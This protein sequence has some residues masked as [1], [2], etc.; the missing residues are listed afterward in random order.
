M[1]VTTSIRCF[2]AVS[3]N[4][5]SAEYFDPKYVF[6]PNNTVKWKKIGHIL[7]KCQYGIS[8]SMNE[9]ENGFPIFRMNEIDS[10]FATK[11]EKYANITLKKFEEFQL[12]ENDVLFN[13]TNSFE[14]VGRTGLVKNQTDSVFASYLVRVVPD[15]SEVLPEFL[16]VYLNTKFGIGQVKRR[17]MPSINQANVSAAELKRVLVPLFSIDVQQGIASLVNSAYREKEESNG[18]YIQAQQLLESE[19]GLDKLKFDKPVGYDANFSEVTESVRLDAQHY[20]PEHSAL[21]SHIKKGNWCY[22]RQLRTYNRR[23]VQPVYIDGGPVNVVNS[24]H[25]GRQH[26]DYDNFQKTSETA[27][28]DAPEAHIKKDDLL[29]YTTGA[30]IGSTNIYLSDEPA[31]ASNH[32]NILRLDGS[33]DPAYMAMVMQSKIGQF[34]TAKHARGSAQAELYPS[35][36]DKFT[37]PIVGDSVAMKIGTLIRESLTKQKES[38]RLLEQ[39]KSRVEKLIEEAVK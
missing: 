23:G 4:R 30:Y 25:I 39:A 5:F 9:S 26:L 13:R 14:F 36:I 7:K 16:T 10:C 34:Q 21:I 15:V 24:Q 8:I 6:T 11:A 17:A 2:D 33:I 29:I 22:L 3:Q 28:N 12:H 19:L 37:V 31:L 35:D 27:F 1:A 18:L 20:R 38:K 32:V